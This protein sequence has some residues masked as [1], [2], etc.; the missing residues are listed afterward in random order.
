[1]RYGN[2][3]IIV[4]K[5]GI[6]IPGKKEPFPLTWL[7]VLIP[8]LILLWTP[9]RLSVPVW[10][11]PNSQV[12]FQAWI[13]AVVAFL[14]WSRRSE[15]N[16]TANELVELFP[17]PRDPRR[18]G[19]LILVILG[20]IGLLLGLVASIP[21]ASMF[22]LCLMICGA[23]FALA[24][25]FLL[26]VVLTPL[27]LLFLM[28]P[29]PSGVLQSLTLRFQMTGAAMLGGALELLATKNRVL[30]TD[31]TVQASGYT[32]Q[33]TPSLSGLGTFFFAI[34]GTLAYIIWRRS[35]FGRG[36]VALIIAGFVSCVVSLLRLLVLGL[37]ANG[38]RSLAET[39]VKIPALPAIVLIWGLTWFFTRRL[40]SP[41]NKVQPE[42]DA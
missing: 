15:W 12:I 24:G 33:V 16:E 13:P 39:C 2:I 8:G 41:R 26:R 22:C 25:P 28:V 32:L 23:C 31:V 5:N 1:V 7:W 38:N 18:S 4:T 42:V 21:A 27:L 3:S 29:F 40:L 10:L 30:F 11:A 35:S 19:N 20:G 17:D 9:F 36:L 6:S 14:W 34:V 37:I